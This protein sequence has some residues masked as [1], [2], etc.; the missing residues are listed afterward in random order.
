MERHRSRG[1]R[2]VTR[3]CEVSPVWFQCAGIPRPEAGGSRGDIRG[4]P[5]PGEKTHV[6]ARSSGS[7]HTLD[8]R[9]VAS[10]GADGEGAKAPSPACLQYDG[11]GRE[12]G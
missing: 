6:P 10:G 8:R 5:Y 9:G 11:K 12:E 1:M 4:K 3:F 2:V 7:P